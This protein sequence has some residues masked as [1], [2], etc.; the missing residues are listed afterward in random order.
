VIGLSGAPTA[1]AVRN[2]CE[3]QTVTLQPSSQRRK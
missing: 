1:V 2:D 3:Q